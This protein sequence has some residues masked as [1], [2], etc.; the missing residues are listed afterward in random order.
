M[1]GQMMNNSRCS[2]KH[3]KKKWAI[4]TFA[5]VCRGSLKLMFRMIS[6]LLSW[7]GALLT[8]PN[9]SNCHTHSHRPRDQCSLPSSAC[10]SPS[11]CYSFKTKDTVSSIAATCNATRNLD[12][13]LNVLLKK[14]ELHKPQLVN[15]LVLHS[16]C[17]AF[18][19]VL[20]KCSAC[21]QTV[22]IFQ[23]IQL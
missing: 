13:F 10:Q 16:T 20:E 17:P 4:F 5:E 7:P 12:H 6:E 19:F 22:K 14:K 18:L 23:K 11:Y 15:D 1:R 21:G 2:E 3:V 9:C 8:I